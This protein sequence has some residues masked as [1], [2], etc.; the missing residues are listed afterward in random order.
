MEKQAS[1]QKDENL[2]RF[3]FSVIQVTRLYMIIN[4]STLY[5]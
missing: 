3:Y 2:A 1:E 5:V 4:F